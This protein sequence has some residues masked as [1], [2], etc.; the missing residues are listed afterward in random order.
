MKK[1]DQ[2]KKELIR[3]RKGI[4]K[5]LDAYQEDL[6]Q[7]DELRSRMPEMRKKEKSLNYELN[8][9]ESDLTDQQVLLKLA[10]NIGNF[11]GKLRGV[12]DTISCTMCSTVGSTSRS[13]RA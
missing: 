6:I 10:D 13:N 12:A 11:L 4:D 2:L 1:N 8:C 9:I 7:L 5:L 3:I